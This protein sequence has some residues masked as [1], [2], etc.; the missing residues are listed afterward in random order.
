M[1]RFTISFTIVVAAVLL[2][3]ASPMIFWRIW[4]G[5]HA[6]QARHAVAAAVEALVRG[7][8]VPQL[9]LRQEV[10]QADL[11]QAF[12]AGYKVVKD[13]PIGLTLNGYEVLVRVRSGDQYNFDVYK[14]HGEWQLD[15]CS[16]SSADETRARQ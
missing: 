7:D 9:H 3:V 10:S 8:V 2:V 13:D 1:K 16:H 4:D 12:S 11:S 5:Y 15:C 6:P 14:A